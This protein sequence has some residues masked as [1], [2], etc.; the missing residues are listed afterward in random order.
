MK[1]AYIQETGPPEKI[2]YGDLPDPTPTGS[3]VLIKTE[4]VALN[5]VDTYI[6]AGSIKMDLPMPFIV[7]CDIAGT[8]VAVGPEASMFQEG[9]RV[10]GT[11]QGL[12]GRQ[13]TFA[14]LVAIEEKWLYPTPDRVSSEDAAAISLVGITAC[15]G[16]FE[17]AAAQPG[18]TLFLTG[19]S[20]GVGSTVLQMATASGVKVITT[21]GSPEKADLCRKLGAAEVIL[22]KEEDVSEKLKSI[23]PDGVNIW[24]D[25]VRSPNF[26]Q[27]VE[28]LKMNGRIVVMAGRE[29]RPE[30]PLGPFYVKCCSLHGFVMFNAEASVQRKYAMQ[31]NEWLQLNKIAPQIGRKMPL[32]EATEAHR[33]QEENTLNNKGSLSGK[34]VLTP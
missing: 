24:W 9:D 28:H 11:N 4:A 13:G 22:Y 29:A 27:A 23:A 5:P 18:E 26:D 6:R 31:I 14:E 15:L 19:G 20:G 16:L 7:G 10:W 12:L 34:I 32:S 33:M 30:F 17:H 25:V 1:A 8:V 21:A 2:Q 3:Q